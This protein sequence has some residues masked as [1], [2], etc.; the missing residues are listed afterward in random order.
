[1][2]GMEEWGETLHVNSN[3]LM[4]FLYQKNN[5]NYTYPCIIKENE[6]QSKTQDK[7]MF[8][9]KRLLS[10]LVATRQAVASVLY[11]PVN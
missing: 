11:P 2:Q 10:F 4:S 6:L 3:H 7:D 1:M 8:V 5:Y 9:A